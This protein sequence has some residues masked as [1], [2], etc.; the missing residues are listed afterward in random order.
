MRKI[1]VLLLLGNFF[2]CS[3]DHK[4]EQSS[5]DYLHR[6]AVGDSIRK[7]YNDS[8]EHVADSIV[9][10]AIEKKLK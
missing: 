5:E 2:S 3:D 10:S 9:K 8:L 7:A 1:L 4:S 6:K